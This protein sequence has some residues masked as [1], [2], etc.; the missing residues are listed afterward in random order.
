MQRE[1]LDLKALTDQARAAGLSRLPKTLIEQGRARYRAILQCGERANPPPNAETDPPKRGRR[2]Q[3]AALNLLDQLIKH[4]DAVLA[5]LVNLA[6]PFD[7]SQ[8]EHDIRMVKVQ[9]KISAVSAVGTAPSLF[10]AFE[11]TSRHCANRDFPC[12]RLC[13]RP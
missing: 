6:V 10:A 1:L 7:N 5:F 8:A 9:Q 11:D 12:F 13:N 2:K 4:E 3:S